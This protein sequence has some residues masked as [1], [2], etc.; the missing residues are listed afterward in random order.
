MLN[1]LRLTASPVGGAEHQIRGNRPAAR[2]IP[3]QRDRPGRVLL[4][5]RGECQGHPIR[6]GYVPYLV[7][8]RQ[9]EHQLG[10]DDLH[11][12]PHMEHPAQEID[13]IDRQAEDLPCRRPRPLP[14]STSTWQRSGSA[15]CIAS[16]CP[17]AHGTTLRLAAFGRLRLTLVSWHGLEGISLSAT[18]AFST[19][20]S[21]V[22]T[23][24]P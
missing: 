14:R 8:L 17:A 3:G 23:T 15:S 6:Q 13:V 16:T 12:T 22:N 1:Q 18:A 21:V 4:Q 2:R 10:T 20:A 19:V 11:L 9:A 7:T 24:R 5:V